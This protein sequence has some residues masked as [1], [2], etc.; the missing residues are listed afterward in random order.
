MRR[1]VDSCTFVNNMHGAIFLE[2][3]SP[4]NITGN[5]VYNVYDQHGVHVA[6]TQNVIEVR[7]CFSHA[8]HHCGR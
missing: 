3:G 1:S 7:A 2:S 8:S 6:T 4:M 5:V